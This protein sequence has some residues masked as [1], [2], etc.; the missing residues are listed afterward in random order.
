MRKIFGLAL[1]VLLLGNSVEAAQVQGNLVAFGDSDSQGI[2]NAEV[3]EDTYDAYYLNGVGYMATNRNKL[4]I[5]EFQKAL[6]L[7]PNN[8]KNVRIYM[9]LGHCYCN[10]FKNQEAVEALNKAVEL[11]SDDKNV[12]SQ[13]YAHRGRAYHQMGKY[14]NAIADVNKAV[15]ISPTPK[16]VFYF[17][18]AISYGKMGNKEAMFQNYAKAIETEPENIGYY[19][20]RATAYEEEKEYKLALADINIAIKKSAKPSEADYDRQGRLLELSG[21]TERSL[22]SFAKAIEINPKYGSAYESRARIYRKQKKYDRALA[23][24]DAYIREISE[25]K[26]KAPA[27][28]VRAIILQESGDNEGAIRGYG[29]AIEF[30]PNYVAAYEA[31]AKLYRD[32]KEYDLALKDVDAALENTRSPTAYQQYLR[33]IILQDRGNDEAALEAFSKAIE[34]DPNYSFAY[35]SR[36]LIYKNLK[37]YDLALQ[38]INAAVEYSPSPTAYYYRIRGDIWE[39][40]GEKEA[41]LIDYTKAIELDPNYSSAYLYRADLY[42]NMGKYDLALSDINAAI[43]KTSSPTAY[44][45]WLRGDILEKSGDREGAI[46]EYSKALE[47][48][49]K[50]NYI[51]EARRSLYEKMG[52]QDIVLAEFDS[53]I[54]EASMPK[55]KAGYYRQ[56][57]RILLKKDDKEGALEDYAKAVEIDPDVVS[58]LESRISF[59]L[60][61]K[62]YDRALSDID[63][64]IKKSSDPKAIA[65]YYWRR[66]RIYERTGGYERAAAEYT[67]AIESDPDHMAAYEARSFAYRYQKKYDLAI[68]DTDVLIKKASNAKEKSEHYRH[69]GGISHSSGDIESAVR[70]YTIAVELDSNN[71][72]AHRDRAQAY[73]ELRKY[74]LALADCEKLV[75]KSPKYFYWYQIRAEIYYQM[76]E[77]DLAVRDF[78]KA[79]ELFP[80][81]TRSA[82][83]LGEIYE[84]HYKDKEKAL[85]H[86]RLVAD[87]NPKLAHASERQ[88][89]GEAIQR[90][91]GQ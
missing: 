3:A 68:A 9:A 54:K 37:K 1:A 18:L 69:R 78:K 42:R 70:D 20:L 49:P 13:V 21:D 14:E 36:S 7:E 83:C 34:I 91:E 85:T 22:Q 11:G 16:A 58:A 17:H 73:S 65:E 30:D 27:Y 79:L 57:A 38:D 63:A 47:I 41:A 74:D 77:M 59:Y 28:R 52:K 61:V 62:E 80:N 4:A 31:R 2:Q 12:M 24:M 53:L 48:N 84:I 45:Y 44:H 72:Y 71:D 10:L 39:K 76:K 81:D 82:Y 55:E 6:A 56:R 87:P 43:E 40:S 50:A 64:L 60:E 35:G 19:R 88:K 86:Y 5:E 29:K 8:V 15:A 23:E 75:Q 51:R 26:Y 90:L 66:G 89:A 32:A 46:G 25:P 67:K 33:G